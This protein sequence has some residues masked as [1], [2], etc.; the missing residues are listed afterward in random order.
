MTQLET[1]VEGLFTVS[2]KKNV[3]IFVLDM[4]DETMDLNKSVGIVG[5][6]NH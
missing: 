3:V 4:Y 1:M 6:G 2:P 5:I